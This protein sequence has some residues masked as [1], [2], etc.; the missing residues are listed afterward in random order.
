MIF[1]SKVVFWQ[2]WQ[3]LGLLG[4]NGESLKVKFL[5]LIFLWSVFAHGLCS[6]YPNPLHVVVKRT[7]RCL[8]SLAPPPAKG[9][10]SHTSLPFLHASH[11]S[12]SQH[13][14]P[15]AKLFIP[16]ATWRGELAKHVASKVHL[17]GL[18]KP[19]SPLSC[20]VMGASTPVFRIQGSLGVGKMADPFEFRYRFSHIPVNP[21]KLV[22]IVGAV[23]SNPLMGCGLYAMPIWTPLYLYSDTLLFNLCLRPS[24]RLSLSGDWTSPP[25]RLGDRL[26][27]AGA[28]I[29][30]GVSLVSCDLHVIRM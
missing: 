14:Q 21:S 7:Q 28:Q 22:K 26:H 30:P 6:C 23:V 1:S 4:T 19:S 8:Y 11:Y 25:T 10:F 17:N 12:F 13:Q 15:L 9:F 24:C 3:Q 27:G 5:L 29:L 16:M 2:G 18:A 20:Y